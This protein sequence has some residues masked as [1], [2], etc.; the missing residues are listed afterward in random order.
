MR[1]ISPNL[2]SPLLRGYLRKGLLEIEGVCGLNI[3]KRCALEVGGETCR[4][5]LGQA[6][7]AS[8]TE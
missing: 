3:K 6:A 4:E 7:A 1:A 8:R 5:S 2:K